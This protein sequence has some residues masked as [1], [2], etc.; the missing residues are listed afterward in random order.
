V[1]W[2]ALGIVNQLLIAEVGY[3]AMEERGDDASDW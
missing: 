3:R 2:L 1:L